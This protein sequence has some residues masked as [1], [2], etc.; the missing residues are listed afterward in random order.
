MTVHQG[1]RNNQISSPEVAGLLNRVDDYMR[2]SGYAES[3]VSSKIFNDSKTIAKLRAGK[4]IGTRRLN[5]AVGWLADA[6]PD[7]APDTLRAPKLPM[8]REQIKEVI[9][10]LHAMDKIG[11]GIGGADGYAVSAVALNAKSIADNVVD[12]LKAIERAAGHTRV[13]AHAREEA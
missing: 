6:M 1:A 10:L 3:T 7:D 13:H 11:D 12:A 9:D 5:H 8:L 2:A 4:D